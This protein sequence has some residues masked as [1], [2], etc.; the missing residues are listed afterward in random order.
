VATRS[1]PIVATTKEPIRRTSGW[2]AQSVD[3]SSPEKG[4]D[5]QRPDRTSDKAGW[6]P[7]RNGTPGRLAFCSGPGHC[8]RHGSIGRR[9]DRPG[10]AVTLN[11]HPDRRMGDLPVL[12]AIARD[13]LSRS[14]FETGI[15][16]GG[17]TAHP[18]AI[19]GRGGAASSAV[20][21]TSYRLRAAKI[22]LAEFPAPN[23]RWLAFV[24]IRPPAPLSGDPGPDNVLLPG[25]RV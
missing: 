19:G 13:G 21:M 17:L 25:H 14:Q 7:W 24:Q 3:K 23:H 10:T 12:E 20:P 18:G 22:R 5:A 9:T 8:P 4:P 2:Q 6:A 1:T 15:S 16:N 11:F